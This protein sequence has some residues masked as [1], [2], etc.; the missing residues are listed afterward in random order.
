MNKCNLLIFTIFTYFILCSSTIQGYL[1][2]DQKRNNN[3]TTL[4]NDGGRTIPRS[5]D[6]RWPLTSKNNTDCPVWFIYNN[7]TQQCECG[8]EI[9]GIVHCDRQKK[10]VFIL[11]CYCMT[12]DDQFGV[13]AGSCAANCEVKRSN[14]TFATYNMQPAT[15]THLNDAMCT[16]RWNRDGRFC[17]K[18]IDDHYVSVYSYTLECFKCSTVELKYNWIKYVASAFLPLTI[19]YLTILILRIDVSHPR[20]ESII[21]YAQ[22]ITISSNIRIV[23][24][25]TATYPKFSP[26][27]HTLAT[28]YGIWNLDFFRTILP[29]TC[30]DVNTLQALTL[31]YLIA[32]YPLLLTIITYILIELH[33]R[34]CIL[35]VFLWKP[36]GKCF[37]S[38]K[39]KANIKSSVIKSF[40]TCLILSYIKLLSVTSD[41]LIPV[42]A[43]DMQGNSVGV[44]LYNDANIKYF[45]KE[46]LPYALLAFIV[47]VTFIIFP[48]FFVAFYT[49]RCCKCLKKWP[50]LQICL[51]TFHGYYKDGTDDSRDYRWF[52]SMFFLGRIVL[53]ALHAYIQTVNFYLILSLVCSLLSGLLLIFKPYKAK[54]SVYN[55]VSV[56]IYLSMAVLYASI[57]CIDVSSVESAQTLTLS[58]IL[59][60]FFSLLPL[61]YAAGLFLKSIYHCFH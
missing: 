61:F 37:S 59:T 32:F 18:C 58:I 42:W 21:V 27:I 26:I 46:H 11:D 40:S 15:L 38:F 33:D 19:F 34:D 7:N 22:V 52:P 48:V 6:G 35:I 28:L 10:R 31:D 12:D 16:E 8:N 20:L 25:A 55:T 13:I 23:L 56:L 45:G 2:R 44:F 17:G 39:N 43:Y 49:L 5:S 50:A 14:T 36:F 53:F 51:D 9:N 54:F 41:I 47:L 57:V 1:Q 3:A 60:F 24:T 29:P 30:L 4:K